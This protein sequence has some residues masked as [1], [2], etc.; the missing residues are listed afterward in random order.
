MVLRTLGAGRRLLHPLEHV[1][2]RGLLPGCGHFW[3]ITQCLSCK[4]KS[5]HEAWYH[6][7]SDEGREQRKEEE[8]EISR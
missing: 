4:Q 1:L 5:P 6:Y 7:P 8:L 3:A 2:D